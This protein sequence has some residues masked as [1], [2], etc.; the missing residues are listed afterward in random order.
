MLPNLIKAF[1]SIAQTPVSSTGVT[2]TSGPPPANL[3]T[4]QNLMTRL[5]NISVPIAFMAVTV[6]LAL[7]GIKYLT[8]GGD[9]KA[10]GAAHQSVTWALMGIIFMI[11]AWL[12]LLLIEAFTGVKVTQFNLEFPSTP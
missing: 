12:L 2:I 4:L 6:V 7:A 9:A 3:E 10:I 5:I 11:L 8:S 1:I